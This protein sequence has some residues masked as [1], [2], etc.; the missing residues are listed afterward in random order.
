[1]TRSGVLLLIVLFTFPLLARELVGGLPRAASLGAALRP[2]EGGVAIEAVGPGSAAEKM[3]LQRDDMVVS[4][5]GAPIADAAALVAAI[6]KKR[7]GDAVAIVV[8]R[9]S[10]TV[11]KEGTLNAAPLEK[12]AAYDIEYGSVDQRRTIVTRPRGAGRHPA[13]LL[14]GGIGCYS[15]DGILRPAEPREPYA[16][17]L[18]AWTRAG[19]VT[20]RVEKSGMGDSEGPPCADPRSDF[21]AEV[22]GFAAGVAKLESLEF[23]D[24]SNVFFFAHSIG[25]LVAARIAAEHPVR[26]IVVAETIGTSWLE[27]DLT[28]VRRQLLLLGLP[29]DEVDRRVRR[30]ELCAHRF[31]IDKQA[32]DANCAREVEGPAPW[33]YMQQLGSLDLAPLWKKIDAPVLIFYGTADFVTDAYQSRYLRDMI[34]AFHPGRATYVEIEGMEHGLTIG[35][36]FAQRLSDETLRFFNTNQAR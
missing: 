2:A 22:R 36:T 17:L 21:D 31:Y 11:T 19:Y 20:M 35:E 34:N 10:E 32:P 29:Y 16:K 13:V 25:P 5:D 4:V 12:Q 24:Q 30:H 23:V 27:Y 3:G 33:T 1:M 26:A 6:T 14:I 18:D 15:L 7:G 8:R 9:G 28:N